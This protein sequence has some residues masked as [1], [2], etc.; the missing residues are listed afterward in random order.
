MSFLKFLGI[1]AM[2]EV[3]LKG[4]LAHMTSWAD[5]R[6][7]SLVDDGLAGFFFGHDCT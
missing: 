6:D 2:L 7:R 1:G 3:L 5:G 4:V